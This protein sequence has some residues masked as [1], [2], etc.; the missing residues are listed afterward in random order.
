MTA[1][2][3]ILQSFFTDKLARQRQASPRTVTAYRDALRLLVQF[4][5]RATGTEPWQLDLGQLDADL[6]S[7]FLDHLEA[8]RGN[9]ARTRNARLA[10]IRSLFR[11]AAWQAPE[12]AATIQRV[13]GISGKRTSTTVIHFL[14]DEEAQALL[15]A[16]D[17][18]TWTGRRDSTLLLLALRT[19]LRVSEL[20][21]LT[22]GDIHLGREAHVRCLGKGRKERYTPL[23]PSTVTALRD[24]LAERGTSPDLPLFC[25][26]QGTP[27]STDA[28]QARLTKYHVIAA[29]DCPSLA[30]RKIS[31][32]TL[33]HSTVMGLLHAGVDIAVLA[34][35]LGHFSGVPELSLVASF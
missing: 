14:T 20:T 23:E 7:A 13:L 17:R 31:P 21:Q 8:D 22:C 29:R 26:R 30:T 32:H 19:G 35:W 15:D 34:L 3:P 1:L 24:W 28:I 6:I 16:P 5:S 12:H 2:A 11:H 27:L 9:S 4:A 18:R 25:T 10:A 33:R